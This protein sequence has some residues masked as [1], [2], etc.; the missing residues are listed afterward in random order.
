MQLSTVQRIGRQRLEELL[1][2]VGTLLIAFAPL[3]VTLGNSR[4]FRWQWLLLFALLGISLFMTAVIAERR[5][6][7]VVE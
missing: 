3:D 5:R 4:E 6:F 2:E 7:R 1:R